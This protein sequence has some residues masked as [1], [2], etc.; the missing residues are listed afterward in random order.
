VARSRRHTKAPPAPASSLEV[1]E[2]IEI[3]SGVFKN[4]CLELM[5]D[6][7]ENGRQYVITKHGRPVA[8]LVPPDHGAERAF[9][10]LRG[11]V[12]QQG[13]IVEPDLDAWGELA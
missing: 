4:T 1:L 13:D 5:D 2:T 10:F 12:V 3:K 7:N 8:K 9:G 6:V 11:T